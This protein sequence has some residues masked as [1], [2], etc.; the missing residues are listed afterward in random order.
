MTQ[1]CNNE[2]SF[3][4]QASVLA[5]YGTN[6]IQVALKQAR[7]E[8]EIAIQDS[9]LHG[10]GE[11]LCWQFSVDNYIPPTSILGWALTEYGDSLQSLVNTP[12]L[13]NKFI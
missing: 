5:W 8:R 4:Y 7:L 3:L 2:S 11:K 6:C 1:A 9:Y 12:S 13:T 10:L